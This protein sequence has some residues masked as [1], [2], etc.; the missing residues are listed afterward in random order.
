MKQTAKKLIHVRVV[1]FMMVGVF[2]TILDFALFNSL[3]AISGNSSSRSVVV[4]CN[5]ISATTVA[6]LSFFLNRKYVFKSQ[7]TPTH[8]TLYFVAIT[9]GG[10]YIVQNGIIYLVLHTFGNYGAS[11]NQLLLI[12]FAKVVGTAG[13]TI[14]N[15]IWYKQVIFNQPGHQ[16]NR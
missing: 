15:Y 16:S 3:L 6:C 8:Y 5:T 2:N 4:I 11:E 7:N 14:W 9:L 13:S 10:L 1:R 12:N